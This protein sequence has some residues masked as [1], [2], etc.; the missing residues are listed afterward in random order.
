MF[1]TKKFLLRGKAS[2]LEE[3]VGCF[4]L[5]AMS[6]LVENRRARFEYEILETFEAGL[7][8]Q[9]TEVK[10]VRLKEVSL[11]EAYVKMKGREAYLVGCHIQP[12]KFGT[13][14]N[15]EEKRD[16]KLLLHKRELQLLISAVE[17]KGQTIVPLKLY[18]KKGRVKVLIGV[19]K[20]K[21]VHDKRQ[22]I[23]EREEKK[24]MDRAIK[25][26]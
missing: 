13:H 11:Q 24:R 25:E 21:K 19:G 23:K 10:S 17:K 20:G 8:L 14:Y 26:H 16:R 6:E 18:L 12:Y 4:I 9:G 7:V 3:I 1:S 2:S 22:T 5:S 15:H